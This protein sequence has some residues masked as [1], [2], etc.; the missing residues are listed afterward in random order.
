MDESLKPDSDLSIWPRGGGARSR[1]LRRKGSFFPA[2]RR[3]IA[4]RVGTRSVSRGFC[5]KSAAPIVIASI[6]GA[7][8]Q[9][10]WE[11][12]DAASLTWQIDL[13]VIRE[14]EWFIVRFEG[15]EDRDVGES[16]LHD[17]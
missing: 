15:G 13:P 10:Q 5:T 6:E 8:F 11:F 1:K 4:N 9:R 2:D 3:S 14:N 17:V 7:L 12:S 16:F